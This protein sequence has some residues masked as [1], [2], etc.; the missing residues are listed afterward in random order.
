MSVVGL[1]EEYLSSL[2][3][4]QLRGLTY[5]IEREKCLDS[6]YYLTKE[7]L[8][9]KDLELSFHGPLCQAIQNYT[10]GSL[11][12]LWLWARGHFKTTIITIAHTIQLLLRD[13]NLRI[14]IASN[15][16]DNA[17]EMLTAIK[18]QFI[19]NEHLRYLFPEAVPKAN[20]EGRIEWGTST[21]VI[22]PNRTTRGLKEASIEVA[23]VDTGIVSRHY[24]IMKKDD[25]VT[26]KSITTP[27]QRK[28]TADWD[29]LS[30]GL[31][32]NIE[33]GRTDWVGTRY[34]LYD[35][36]SE[37][38]VRK[39][40]GL[41]SIIPAISEDGNTA[42][43]STRFSI[44]SLNEIAEVQGPYI[45]SCQYDLNPVPDEERVFQ[46]AWIQEFVWESF[47]KRMKEEEGTY[48]SF[49]SET[50]TVDPASSK[51]KSS[52]LTALVDV[53]LLGGV[54]YVLAARQGKWNPTERVDNIFEEVTNRPSLRRIGI[55]SVGFQET[56]VHYC[57]QKQLES[58]RFR[59]VRFEEL[60]HGGRSKHERIEGLV[61]LFSQGRILLAP[62]LLMLKSQLR[63]HPR[64][65]H[66]DLL[67]AL[68]YQLDMIGEATNRVKGI[69]KSPVIQLGNLELR[70]QRRVIVGTNY[71]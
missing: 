18:D 5:E 20:K 9:Y 28:E 71:G 24:D 41:R 31:F 3:D 50:L 58:E 12:R 54:W 45:Y 35:L 25:L 29:R 16:L 26:P 61:P 62:G 46:E 14:L 51:K 69:K 13:P 34:H 39:D 11:R 44:H 65:D 60:K 48:S 68:A 36:Y 15:K 33:T 53:V 55:E 40:I 19:F 2:S 49:V 21:S 22:M 1:T 47:W 52:D 56:M 6:L 7:V 42:A 59:K 23:G 37:L 17:K 43:F 32:D 64:G 10:P 70:S 4:E 8:G 66:E 67:D 38:L 30:I 27:E 57:R 63:E